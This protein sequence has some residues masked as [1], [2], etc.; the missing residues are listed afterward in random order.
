MQSDAERIKQQ[1]CSSWSIDSDYRGE[2]IRF[3]CACGAMTGVYP[4]HDAGEAAL[5]NHLE[6]QEGKFH[7]LLVASRADKRWPARFLRRRGRW[8]IV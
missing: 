6:E 2:A 4:D 7:R 8:R 3:K 1:V 5:D